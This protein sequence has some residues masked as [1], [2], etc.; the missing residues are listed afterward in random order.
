MFLNIQ[1]EYLWISLINALYVTY[2]FF[3][4][5]KGIPILISLISVQYATCLLFSVPLRE[6]ETRK[7]KKVTVMAGPS[8][9]FKFVLYASL[10]R[11]TFLFFKQAHVLIGG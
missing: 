2:L 1:K 11:C 5:Q 9:N 8:A 7:K 10:C 4:I 6:R 3:N